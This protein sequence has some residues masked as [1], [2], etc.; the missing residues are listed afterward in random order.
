MT[1]TVAYDR[2]RLLLIGALMVGLLAT[3]GL[4]A[5]PAAAQVPPS[6]APTTTLPPPPAPASGIRGLVTSGGFPLVGA[7]VGFVDPSTEQVLA[8]TTTGVNGRYLVG[9][10]GAGTYIAYAVAPGNVSQFWFGAGL[11]DPSVITPTPITLTVA[12]PSR[13]DVSFDFP[14]G[15]FGGLITGTTGPLTNAT[16]TFTEITTG[17]REFAVVN[18]S[19]GF[20][21]GYVPVGDYEVTVRW[22]GTRAYRFPTAYATGETG[23]SI[24][25]E[26]P[27][28]TGAIGGRQP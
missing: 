6:T 10:L 22:D 28:G 25:L 9:W 5:T 8:E 18:P 16:A 11:V 15:G 27:T 14:T 19:G 13:N 17:Y 21:L 7:R 24:A 12:E 20:G 4:G 23:S 26:V 2:L 1:P 3:V